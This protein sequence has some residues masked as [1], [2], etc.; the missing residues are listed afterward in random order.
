[1][2][3]MFFGATVFD[4]DIGDWDVSKVDNMEG[5][6]EGATLDANYDALLAGWSMLTLRPGIDFHAGNS[7]YCNQ[8]AHNVLTDPPNEWQITDRGPNAF[9]D[10]PL[11]F[12]MNIPDQNYKVGETVSAILP[13][14]FYGSGD[15]SYDLDGP[16]P[17]GL[18]FTA[19]RILIGIPRMTATAV[20]LNY[21]VEDNALTPTSTTL[22]FMV[23]VDKGEQTSF[24]FADTT[25][26]KTTGDDPFT[27]TAT[28]GSGDGAV[29]YESDDTAVATVDNSG[30]VTIVAIGRTT[31][32]AT[33]AADTNYNEATAS[34]TLIVTLAP[35]AFDTRI[36]S[37]PAPAYIYNVGSTVTLSL[38]PAIGG[39]GDLRYT[40]DGPI[41]DGLSF[42]TAT[43]TARWYADH[44]SY[45]RHPDLH[46]HR[47]CHADGH[48]RA[49][50]YRDDQ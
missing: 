50:L 2:S 34:Y 49:D 12:Y 47:Q 28:G 48:R 38:P 1:M 33:K 35:L 37:A 11:G 27:V 7:T 21:I 19:N 20:T 45:R 42:T 4:Q 32:T 31:I 29:T 13:E 15:L 3:F 10:C 36:I 8:P 43:A 22:T 25:V 44:D 30:K 24:V 26:R 14:A 9:M 17:V 41:P 39:T 40:L 16:I 5:M 46:R 23:T 18:S 6:F